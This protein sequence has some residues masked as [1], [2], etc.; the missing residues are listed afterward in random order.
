MPQDST[1]AS[2]PLLASGE[3]IIAPS[4][5]SADFARLSESIAMVSAAPWIHVDVMDGHFVP[6]ITIGP[7][8][9][10]AL[11]RSTRQYLDVHLMI[12]HPELYIN[13]FAQAGADGL[14]VHMEACPHLHRVLQQIRAAGMRPG[15]SLNPGTDIAGLEWVLDNTDLILVMTVN[16]GF[17]GQKYIPSM[18]AKVAAIRN[19]LLK[20]DKACVIEV[21]GGVDKRTAPILADAGA[22]VFVAGTAVFGQKDPAQA[23][24]ELS[25]SVTT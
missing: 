6:N 19:L 7:P 15:V 13:A 11:R 22:Q 25:Q 8:V 20:H 12:E 5:L 4:L 18:A 3:R 21:D 9:V 10:V 23:L 17:G 2:A 16:P 14:T 24:Q 1:K